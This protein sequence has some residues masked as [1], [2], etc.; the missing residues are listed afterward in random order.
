MRETKSRFVLL[1]QQGLACAVVTA[2]V[3]PAANLVSLDIVDTPPATPSP[4][5]SSAGSSAGSAVG[6]SG[7][8]DST[9]VVSTSPVRP[10]VSS[11]P[12]G[13]VTK[14]GLRALGGGST[15]DPA[16]GTTPGTTSG[17][18]R[19]ASATVEDLTV[20]SAPE[21]VDGLAT[22]GV[23]WDHD[24]RVPEQD[25]SIAV[26]TRS[27]GVWSTWTK[28]PYH[29][30]E[31]PDPD[32]KEGRGSEPGTD[33]VYVGS[34]DDV[35][36]RAVTAD[37]RVPRGM[38]LALVDPGAEKAAE[39]E[40]PAIDTGS[41]RLSADETEPAA[42]LSASGATAKP[43]IYSRAQWGAD[44]R[45]RDAGS[46]HYGEVH[47]GFVHHTVNA[48]GY[49]RK[50]VP[51]ILRGIYA[52]HTQSRGWSDIGY[53]FLVDRFGRI[54]EGR[55]GGVGRP[56]VGAHTLGYNDDAFA[57][58]AI[59]NYDTARPSAAMLDAYGR[60]F[61]WKLS[62]HGVRASSMRQW[63]TKRYLPAIEGHRDVGQ[64][65]CPGKYLYAKIP[66]I[67]TLATRYQRAFTGRARAATVAGTTNPVIVA[68][69]RTTRQAYLI[70]SSRAGRL[71]RITA[72]GAY[73]RKADL[74][75]GAG[76][77]DQD[78]TG[79]VI[80]RSGATGRLYLYRGTKAG[81]LSAPVALSTASFHR[82]RLLT[83][84]GDLTGDG[85]PDL[86][87]QPIG[88]AMRVYP[89]R[90]AAGGFRAS[91]VVHSYL[92]AAG[93]VGLGLWNSDGS[94]DTLVRRRDGVLV[95]YAGNGPGGLVSGTRV[96][97]LSS[98]YDWFLS[99]GDLVADGHRDLVVRTRSTGRLWVLP[100]TGK[101]FGA[102]QAFGTGALRFDLAG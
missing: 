61:A 86:V 56:V 92:R 87:G 99:P 81:R 58:S 98:G 73:L 65:A 57:M 88:K 23:T 34:V 77:W 83:A 37:G 90:G 85:H 13:G 7:G 60:L 40:H 6:S 17:T 75:L 1:C 27:D 28:V 19:L 66:T 41:L 96:G 80:T 43:Q 55:Y 50:Q 8:T 45:M 101:G 32:S 68:R 71:A 69:D 93:Q 21:P 102:R 79:D 11:V 4:A 82:V 16:P 49:T 35:Q 5:G 42:A 54:W 2:L 10:T 46:L 20:L 31:A 14:A 12:L 76:D 25:I 3:A 63:I 78:G 39:P 70:R 36:V 62:L 67:R 15:S 91:Y 18:A 22:V 44:E 24:V 48:N 47:G 64:T 97:E 9:S 72:T 52:Y 33:P 51:A 94:P 30:D 74:V 53:N 26:R 29:D 38:Q 59:G 100:G 95:S 89:G 84:V